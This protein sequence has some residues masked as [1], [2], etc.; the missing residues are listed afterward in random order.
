[1]CN[2]ELD[3]VIAVTKAERGF[4]MPR[5]R[6]EALRYQ[7][8]RGNTRH[9]I[10]DAEIQVS[11]GV[12]MRVAEAALPMVTSDAQHDDWLS[13]RRSVMALKLRS[14]MCVPLLLEGR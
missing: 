11:W 9:L 2:A 5:D 14:I 6:P 4:L 3:Q 12:L 1:M 8:A 7:V 10:D 13:G